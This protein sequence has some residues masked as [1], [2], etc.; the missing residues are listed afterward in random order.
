LHGPR[1]PSLTAWASQRGE[2]HSRREQ[3]GEPEDEDSR[4]RDCGTN[5]AN[6]T[7]QLSLSDSQRRAPLSCGLACHERN[8]QTHS[9][10]DACLDAVKVSTA[11]FDRRFAIRKPRATTGPTA[12]PGGIHMVFAVTYI[13]P[14]VGEFELTGD[15]W[16]L[17]ED[18]PLA[19]HTERLHNAAQALEFIRAH[20]T[21]L[22]PPGPDAVL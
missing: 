1:R 13:E 11:S 17:F 16:D 20:H 22:R 5:F 6:P 21:Q 19:V 9:G 3:S 4:K 2:R 7:I 8:A 12:I 10:A 18:G 14:G 15:E